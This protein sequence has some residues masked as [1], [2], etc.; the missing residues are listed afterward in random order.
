MIGYVAI[1]TNDIERAAPFYDAI[2][3]EFGGKRAMNT[4]R[5]IMWSN[6]SGPAIFVTRPF[7]GNPAT[8]GNGMMV[9]LEASSQAQV[10]K[11]HAAAL[12]N[13]GQDEGAPGLRGDTF[14]GGYFRDV[15]GNKLCVF[16]W[17]QQ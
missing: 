9:S 2:L 11:V 17:P 14:Y 12:A 6:G 3:A 16:H 5:G 7:D 4:D 8:V 10:D 15:D 1:G 13:G